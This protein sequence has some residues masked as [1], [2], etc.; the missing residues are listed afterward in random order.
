V[1]SGDFFTEKMRFMEIDI[2]FIGGGG[3][4]RKNVFFLV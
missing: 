3:G 2:R 4:L 1:N